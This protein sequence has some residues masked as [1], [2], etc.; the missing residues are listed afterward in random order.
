MLKR[1]FNTIGLSF[2]LMLI[3]LSATG[4]TAIAQ[5][6]NLKINDELYPMYKRAY[7]MRKS[8][9][10]LLIADSIY[11]KA[12]VMNDPRTQAWAMYVTIY[13]Y[14]SG[15]N[16]EKIMEETVNKVKD[17]SQK[18]GFDD[19]YYLASINYINYLLNHRKSYIALDYA[20]AMQKT[21]ERTGS[22]YG[23]YISLEAIANIH[24]RRNEFSS[25]KDCYLKALKYAQDNIPGKKSTITAYFRI[26]EC[27]NFIKQYDDAIKYAIMG[28]DATH[29]KTTQLR[30]Y[31]ELGIAYYHTGQKQKFFDLYNKIASDLTALLYE[32]DRI[33][34]LTVIYHLYNND[35][36]A[37]LA[38]ARNASTEALKNELQEMIYTQKGDYKQALHYFNEYQGWR[39]E[40]SYKLLQQDMADQ[41]ILSG[42]YKLREQNQQ[43]EISNAQLALINSNLE[44]K[45]INNKAE[46]DR[47]RAQHNILGMKKKQL[48]AQNIKAKIE[49]KAIEQQKKEAA[50]R[51]A[52]IHMIILSTGI[53]I[54]LVLLTI[55][56]LFRIRMS[57]KLRD[58]NKL[59]DIQNK[60]LAKAREHAEQATKMKTMFIQNMSHEI[61]T[62]LNAIVGFSQILAEC[63]DDVSDEEKCDFSNRIEQSSD[64]IL[65][66]INDILDLSSIESGNYKMQLAE[67]KVNDMCRLATVTVKERVPAG[68]EMKFSSDVDDSYSIV[69]DSKRVVQVIINFLTNATK[70]TTE[71]YIH[72]HCSV[73]ENIGYVSFIVADTG[74]G[75]APEKMDAIFERF[76]KLDNFKQGAGLGLSICSIITERLNGLIY[77]DR[78]Y[79]NGAR[80]V[81]A[82]PATDNKH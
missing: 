48:E 10:C 30:N 22:K 14:F 3:C 38:V 44:L 52:R 11:R 64:L 25:A 13:Y 40:E 67:A 63:S 61:R 2:T 45:S 79:T 76:N 31:I 42:N 81:F 29:S 80:F 54:L 28:V 53:G 57:H 43:M 60:E 17:F 23:Q 26:A 15:S 18:H 68:V 46:E 73:T 41:E 72:L 16:N 51:S 35:Y 62:P 50:E 70:N 66:I 5:N 32:R 77:I 65:N 75:V 4:G 74:I 12:V 27:S 47:M 20:N 33:E 58:S 78:N 36:E 21:A 37:A 9:E 34:M 8:P 59:L 19:I 39:L 82:I 71:G 6:N 56:L 55:Y 1:L 69:T 7:Q 49:T 24:F